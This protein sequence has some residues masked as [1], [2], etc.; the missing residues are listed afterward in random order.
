MLWLP[1]VA[2]L[3]GLG[4]NWL[5]IQ[6]SFYPTHFIGFNRWLGW[7]GVI[8]R[9]A[10]KM[11]LICVDRTLTRFGDLDTVF[12]QLQPELITRQ[13]LS[14]IEPRIDEYIDDIMEEVQPVLWD[15]LPYVVRRRIYQWARQQLPGRIQALVEEFGDDLGS[16]VDLRMLITHELQR[17]PELMSRIFQEA[18]APEFRFVIRSGLVIGALAGAALVPLW[19]YT[20]QIWMLPLCGF[21]IGFLTNWLALNLVFRPLNPRYIFGMKFQGLFLKR[22]KEISEVWARIVAEELVTV[23]KVAYAMLHGEHAH[24]TQAILHRH[25]R[26]ILDDS[27][28]MR[29]M[30]QI[31]MGMSGY[32]ELKKAINEKAVEASSEA[33]HD[34]GFN[35]DRAPIVATAIR[36]RMQALP[37]G[38]FQDV[39][40]PAFQ[41]EEWQLMLLGGVLGAM[42]GLIQW[43][44]TVFSP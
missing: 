31:T 18:G 35:R 26:P 4:T 5:A 1:I 43:A 14:Q 6:M 27:G 17:N 15:N 11:A 2:G 37:P 24:R 30:T 33:L 25:I 39:L 10:R 38:E 23:E 3:I 8:P 16:L 12:Y 19:N 36:E 34:N 41:E 22:Q 13:I 20:S 29:L 9:K 21:T 40:R 42:T 7:Q 32:T 44:F 28:I